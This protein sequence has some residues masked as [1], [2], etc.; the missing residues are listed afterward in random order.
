MNNWIGAVKQLYAQRLRDYYVTRY[1]AYQAGSELN[2]LDEFGQE[3]LILDEALDRLPSPIHEFWQAAIAEGD[4]YYPAVYKLPVQDQETYALRITTDGDDGWLVLFDAEGNLIASAQTYIE[5]IIWA[6]D[7]TL[8][9]ISATNF[10]QT[11]LPGMETA[12]SQTFWGKVD[13][14]ESNAANG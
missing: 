1:Q 7:Q 10:L 4:S 11:P 5:V 8:P 9:T 3:N 14:S 13:A 12:A 6:D 2:E